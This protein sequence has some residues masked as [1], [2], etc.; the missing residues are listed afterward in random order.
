M[1]IVLKRALADF[2]R[3]EVA[4]YA[5]ETYNPA[6]GLSAND[7]NHNDH[8][9]EADKFMRTRLL[10]SSLAA[11]A[12][13]AAHADALDGFSTICTLDES[14]AV[15]SSTL[16]AFGHKEDFSYR[17]LSG[18]FVCN[19]KTF[20]I[21]GKVSAESTCMT[22][23]SSV[24]GSASSSSSSGATQY[25]EAK[26]GQISTGF[27]AIVS[28]SSGKSLAIADG[29]E[30][31]GAALVQQDFTGAAYQ[32]WQ[33]EDLGDGYYAI[34]AQ[35]S[36]KALDLQDFTNKDGVKLQQNPWMN[37]WDQHWVIQKLNGGFYRITSRQSNQA[38][39]V[40]EMNQMNGGTVC[41]W[42]YWGGDNQQWR[43]LPITPPATAAATS[44]TANP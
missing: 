40:Y 34:T 30:E 17:T 16:V 29:S 2:V 18:N 22:L 8:R 20:G 44:A 26:P 43:L 9:K 41:L 28:R 37:S 19:G 27:Y 36:E 42:T 3:I 12:F 38:L 11:L 7:K 4:G 39:D 33:V 1:E 35:H 6:A 10:Y 13:P 15:E 25:K 21:Q 32:I 14:C 24:L 31:D 5:A 23:D